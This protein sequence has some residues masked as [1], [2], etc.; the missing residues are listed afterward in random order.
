MAIGFLAKD[1][2]FYVQMVLE[3]FF[4]I[5]LNSEVCRPGS[6]KPYF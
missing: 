1:S 3:Y 4:A 2:N 6:P 5:L